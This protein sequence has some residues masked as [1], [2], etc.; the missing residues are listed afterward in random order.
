MMAVP[1]ENAGPAV[2]FAVLGALTELTA[3]SLLLNRLGEGAKPYQQ[4][5]AGK[6]LEV[7]EV[8]TQRAWPARCSPAAT[9]RRQRCP[10]SRCSPRPR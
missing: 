5:R 7:G 9:G 4:G 6:L 2:R 3:K 8:L 1:G 10:G